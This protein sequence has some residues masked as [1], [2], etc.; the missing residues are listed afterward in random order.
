[1][2][3]EI[4]RPIKGF[5]DYYECSNMG[6]IRSKD[7]TIIKSNGVFHHRKEKLL[8]P[9][10]NKVNQLLQVMLIVHKKF[11]LMY[12]HRIIAEAFVDNPHG[13]PNVTH[14]NGDDQ[15]NRAENLKWVSKSSK[16]NKKLNL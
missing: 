5:S 1:M 6:R 8:T 14:I 9:H 16:V 15:D 7:R 12:V 11:K 10:A 2:E 3:K 4:W 13:L